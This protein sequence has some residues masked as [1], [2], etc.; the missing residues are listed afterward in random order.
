MFQ[1][2]TG[3]PYE[4]ALYPQEY[5]QFLRDNVRKRDNYICQ[6]C[7]ITEKEHLISVRTILNCHHVDYDKKNN[8]INNLI[9]LCKSCNIKANKNRKYWK[10]HYEERMLLNVL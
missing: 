1:G 6:E 10:K 3:I 4:N 7:E 9:T 8:N 5:N 2:G